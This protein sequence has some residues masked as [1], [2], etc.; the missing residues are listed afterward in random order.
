MR[1]SVR[2]PALV[3]L[4]LAPPAAAQLDL[5]DE[6]KRKLPD[7]Q[8]VEIPRSPRGDLAPRRRG[9]SRRAV[10]DLADLPAVVQAD[11][12]PVVPEVPAALTPEVFRTAWPLLDELRKLD[13]PKN[14][15][16]LRLSEELYALGD[17]GLTAARAALT[18]DHA[19]SLVAGARVLLLGG[20]EADRARVAQR[21]RANLPSRSVVPLLEV[22]LERDPMLASPAFLVALLEHSQNAMRAAAERAI[23]P[24]LDVTWLPLLIARVRSERTDTRMRSLRLIATQRDPSILHVLIDRLDDRSAKVA[25]QASRLLALEDD[26]RTEASLFDVAFT[27]PRMTRQSAY[28]LLSLC[29]REDRLGVGLIGEERVAHLLENLRTGRPFVAAASAVALAGAGFRSGRSRDME[30]LDNEVPHELVRHI[31]G[32][33]FHSDFISVQDPVLRRLTLLSGMSYGTDGPGWRDWW[34]NAAGDFRANRAILTVGPEEHG[35]LQVTY[36]SGPPRNEVWRLLGPDLTRAGGEPDPGLGLAVFLTGSECTDLITV[37]QHE[38]V[39][40]VERLPGSRLGSRIRGRQLDVRVAGQ[41]KQFRFPVISGPEREE[42]AWFGRVATTVE[43]LVERNRWQRYPAGVPQHDLWSAEQGWWQ[44]ERTDRA[45]ALRLKALV[46][47][48]LDQERPFKR[49]PAIAELERL[50][51]DEDVAQPADF[52]KLLT[53]LREEIFFVERVSSLV[54]L[55]LAAARSAGAPATSD[56]AEIDPA[57]GRELVDVIATRFELQAAEEVLVVLQVA[58]RGAVRAA[59]ADERP[60][61]RSM[62]AALL[63]RD[64]SPE[65]LELLQ[66]LLSDADE[67]VEAAA[68]LALAENHVEEARNEILLR[69]RLGSPRVRPAALRAVGVLAEP[70]DEDALDALVAGLADG[71]PHVQAAALDGMA[72]LGDP[73]AASLVVRAF[74][75]GR[76]SMLFEPARKALLVLGAA[77]W[78]DLLR[79]ASSAATESRREAALLL[80]EQGVPEAASILMSILTESPSDAHVASELAVLTCVDFRDAPDP[81]RS[82]WAWWDSVVHNDSLTWFRAALERVGLSAPSAEAF[83]GEG[84]LEGVLVLLAA[85]ERPERPIAERARREIL[86]VT[87]SDIGPLPARGSLRAAWLAE[88]RLLVQERYG[89]PR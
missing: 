87:G 77:A 20:D 26:S 46:F 34:V 30:W 66:T 37:L 13:N 72:E 52:P 73:R 71:N 40:G 76:D 16:A 45:R 23:R 57:L 27:D 6:L 4:L 55:A 5:P 64:P 78:P 89:G 65:D 36:R 60:L 85:M 88:L 24:R 68:V 61:V 2:G 75:R 19:A 11:P 48:H 41:G 69:A 31:S 49:G 43:A 12:Y 53:L 74:S 3:L 56:G 42:D 83:A 62:S 21:M 18:S 22:V 86:R 29:E 70:G 25:W 33:V 10:L 63:A 59:A 38:G 84:T 8:G 14:P 47:A 17:S 28:A 7:G 39:F 1:P 81:S 32:E 15:R 79:V 54:D 58:G 35:T 9:T 44:I 50:Y 67:G 51:A 80:S 82:W